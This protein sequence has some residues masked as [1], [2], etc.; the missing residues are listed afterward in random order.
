MSAPG[1]SPVFGSSA[2]CPETYKNP[3]ARMA[4]EYGPMGFGPRSV[5]ITSLILQSPFQIAP[6]PQ[7]LPGNAHETLPALPAASSI[8]ARTP[9]HFGLLPG[10]KLQSSRLVPTRAPGAP[11]TCGSSP[12]EMLP[13][14]SGPAM[15]RKKENSLLA[16]RLDLPARV[17]RSSPGSIAARA[18]SFPPVSPFLPRP[19]AQSTPRTPEARRAEA[20]ARRILDSARN[21]ASSQP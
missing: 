10:R 7:R 20:P 1:I 17:P 11:A 16:P 3:F 2:T 15:H 12:F 19:R 5:R 21:P 9:R 13:S 6:A 18:G 4:C 14:H 8:I